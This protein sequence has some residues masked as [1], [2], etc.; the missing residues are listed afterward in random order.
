[1]AAL[2]STFRRRSFFALGAVTFSLGLTAH[3]KGLSPAIARPLLFRLQS[4][5]PTGW[6]PLSSNSVNMSH[7]RAPQPPPRWDHSA[8]DILVLTKEAIRKDKFVRFL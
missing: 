1:M 2:P 7:L 3:W 4:T 8:E 6:L 5:V